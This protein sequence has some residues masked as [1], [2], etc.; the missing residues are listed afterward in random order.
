MI[1][2]DTTVLVHLE[3]P[4]SPEHRRTH[5]LLRREIMDG[6]Q[7][8]A[9]APQ[10]LTEFLH[11]VTDPRRFQRPLSMPQALDRARFWWNAA[12]VRHVFPTPE[13]TALFLDWLAQHQLGRKRL[14]DTHLAATLWSAGVRRLMTSNPRDFAI[15]PGFEILT[16]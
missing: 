14:L 11:I 16:T 4:E 10:V 13:S 5:E 12:E 7:E 2:I 9:L 15:F 3:I 8:L 6:R 1:G